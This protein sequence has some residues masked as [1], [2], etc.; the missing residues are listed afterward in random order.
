MQADEK[1]KLARESFPVLE[2]WAYL[3]S[4][5]VGPVSTIY[6]ETLARCTDEDLRMGR[7]WLRRWDRIGA[8][9]ERIRGEIATLLGTNPGRILLT[10]STS[11]G[12]RTLLG[13]LDWSAGDEVVTTRLEFPACADAIAELEQTSQV[14]VH[15]AAVPEMNHDALDWLERCVTPRTRLIAFSGVAFTTGARL[16]IE[17]IADFAAA[18]GIPTLVD[19]AQLVGAATPDVAATRVDFMALPLQKW[20]CG[21]EGLG[22]LYIREG[23]PCSRPNEHL[24]HGWPVLE[25]AAEHLKWMRDALRWSW[26]HERTL[27]LAAHARRVL[28]DLEQVRLV[29]PEAHAGLVAVQCPP[30]TSQPL[31]DHLKAEH[32]IV[33]YRPELDL[34]RI[35][36]AFFTTEHE[37]DRYAA[38]I[39]AYDG[40]VH[41]K[42]A[43]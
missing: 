11:D 42:Y 41:S 34:L 36:T 16:P 17:R 30:D 20:L 3:D 22:A 23:A 15:S 28:Q 10:R 7:A 40:Q 4:G 32:M 1:V 19:G 13:S 39:R 5:S 43:S 9:K 27:R 6:A 35:S 38:A 25:A 26:I 12:V 37:I 2:E 24:V 14:K 18:R 31:Y 21:P 33:R 29:T 8:A